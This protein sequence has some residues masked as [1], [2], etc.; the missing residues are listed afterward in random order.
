[1]AVDVDVNWVD[2]VAR[3]GDFALTVTVHR[4]NAP[5]RGKLLYQVD[6]DLLKSAA[7]KEDPDSTEAG[8]RTFEHWPPR[9]DS[10]FAV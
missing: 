2:Q 5:D 10:A 1:V 3:L 8:R 4:D 9:A 6:G 7:W